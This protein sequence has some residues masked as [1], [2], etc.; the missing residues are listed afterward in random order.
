[1]YDPNTHQVFVSRDVLFHEHA[2]EGRKYDSLGVWHLP[3]DYDE[4][5][6]EEED[7]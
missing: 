3:N 1:M 7:V 6:K 4:S 5:V 2:K